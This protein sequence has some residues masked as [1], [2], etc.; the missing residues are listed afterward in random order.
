MIKI[1]VRFGLC[2]WNF[3]LDGDGK[4]F[5]L[6]KLFF[7]ILYSNGTQS[8]IRPFCCII[9]PLVQIYKSIL[10]LFISLHCFRLWLKFLSTFQ[11]FCAVTDRHCLN[12]VCTTT[13][14]VPFIISQIILFSGHFLQF[15]HILR[16]NFYIFF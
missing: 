6:V 12:F 10:I 15:L 1:A 3:V 13:F 5:D 11:L 14:L 9:L 4:V 7:S 2:G 16:I 8:Y